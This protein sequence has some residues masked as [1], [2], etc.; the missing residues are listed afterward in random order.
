MGMTEMKK[1]ILLVI[2]DHDFRG[3]LA[4]K[5]RGDGFKVIEAGDFSKILGLVAAES[6][7]LILM[8]LSES[9]GAVEL[10][11]ELQKDKAFS[12]IPTIIFSSQD[13]HPE[14][15]HIIKQMGAAD[16][17]SKD[18]SMQE[19]SERIKAILSYRP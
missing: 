18:I 4:L 19:F 11:T 9:E 2:P 14:H 15:L 13:H 7:D 3:L 5:L 6:P 17:L 1:K 12:E 10:F 16:V 8:D